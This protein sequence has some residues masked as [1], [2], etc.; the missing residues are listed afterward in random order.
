MNEHPDIAELSADSLATAVSE[1][2]QSCNVCSQIHADIKLLE[3]EFKDLN[4]RA[5]IPLAIDQKI[6]QDI[7]E[8]S[9]EI[10]KSIFRK[11]AFVS[12][13][14]IAAVVILSFAVFTNVKS[15]D[16]IMADINRDGE[17]NVLDSLLLAQ[18]IDKLSFDKTSDLNNDGVLDSKDLKLV[19]SAV[20]SLDGR[21]P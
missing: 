5:E 17:V 14:A 11:N 18:K 20:V 6:Y 21:L 3:G 19:R 8:R 1:H 2:L 16:P 9:K 12:I 7:S 10:R 13:S 15:V 4:K